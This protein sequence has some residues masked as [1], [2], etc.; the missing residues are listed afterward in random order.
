[1][2]PYCICVYDGNKNY[3]YYL[4]DYNNYHDM[5]KIAISSLLKPKYNNYKIYVHNLSNFD[6]AF[7]LNLLS[8]IKNSHLN[9]IRKD[10]KILDLNLSYKINNNTF[11]INF[12]ESLLLLPVSLNK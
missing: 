9:I 5:I 12:R 7:F 6:A 10:T 11:H 2:I 8:S 1:M 3:S 4:T